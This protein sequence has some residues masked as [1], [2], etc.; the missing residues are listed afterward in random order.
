MNTKRTGASQ[1][2]L[3][4]SVLTIIIISL[5]VIDGVNGIKEQEKINAMS[6]QEKAEYYIKLSQDPGNTKSQARQYAEKAK[7]Y[8]M[9]NQ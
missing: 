7:I 4:T 9:D 3:F 2:T 6:S 5:L 8:M 1:S